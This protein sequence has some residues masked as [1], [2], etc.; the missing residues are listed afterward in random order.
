MF[1]QSVSKD[2]QKYNSGMLFK[3]IPF[4]DSAINGV[5]ASMED[6]RRCLDPSGLR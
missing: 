3:A 2:S 1:S 4:G 6:G 5:T